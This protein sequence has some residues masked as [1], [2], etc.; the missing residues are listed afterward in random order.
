MGLDTTI[1]YRLPPTTTNLQKSEPQKVS[2][3]DMKKVGKFLLADFSV[4]FFGQQTYPMW[5][6]V[7]DKN[8]V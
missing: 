7:C 8:N 5:I 2:V 6:D 3:S 4:A 1:H